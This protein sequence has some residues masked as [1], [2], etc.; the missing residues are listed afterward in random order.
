MSFVQ[1][2]ELQLT[3]AGPDG[4]YY[5]R[6]FNTWVGPKR[7][8][9]WEEKAGPFNTTLYLSPGAVSVLQGLGVALPSPQKTAPAELPEGRV[10][11]LGDA[12]DWN[13]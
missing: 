5:L 4:L 9:M 11:M 6:R 1:H 8:V 13:K 2:V 3:Q 10:M 7:V 12:S